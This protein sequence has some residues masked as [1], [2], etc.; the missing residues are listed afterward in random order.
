[1]WHLM[2]FLLFGTAQ[3]QPVAKATASSC[4]Q[5]HLELEGE[6][7]EPAKLSAQDIHFQWG[8]SCNNCHGGDPTVGIDKGS[9]EDSMSR[10]KGYIGRPDRRKIAAL[11]ASCH[12]NPDSMRRYNPQARVDQYAEYLTSVHGRKYQAG[13]TNVATCTDCHGAHGVRPVKNPNS[14]VYATNVAATCG[15]CHAD[16]KKMASYGI[17]TNQMD[18]YVTSVHGVA[19]VKNRDLAAPTCNSCHGNHGAAPPGVDSVANVCGQCHA[20]Q[21]DMFK[22]SPHQKAFAEGNLPACVTCHEHHDIKKTS[23]DML[24]T[25]QSTI[26]ATCHD[27]DSKGYAAAAA[28]KAGIVGLKKDLETAGELLHKAETAGMEVSRPIY[29]LTEGKDRLVR[30]RVN[31]HYFDPVALRKVLDEG[32]KIARTSQ[33]SG[34]KA[35]DELAFRRKGLAVSVVILLVMIALLLLKIRQISRKAG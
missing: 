15:R 4:V 23:D 1:M 8:L 11:C 27:K 12:S 29:D 24:G 20:M 19:L 13:D 22:K 35:L 6:L 3:D 21:W 9:A 16:A 26:C 17:P 32:E 30:A 28:M 34:S 5:C 7:Q 2:L 10:A 33:Q 31:V 25:E 14:P 18:L